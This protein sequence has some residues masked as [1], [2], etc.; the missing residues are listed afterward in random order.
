MPSLGP[1]K[2]VTNLSNC[3]ATALGESSVKSP[4]FIM[5]Y[6]HRYIHEL[7]D[8]EVSAVVLDTALLACEDKHSLLYA[9][10]RSTAGSRYYDLNNLGKARNAWDEALKIRKAILPHSSPGGE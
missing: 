5:T 7:G 4:V 1:L 6:F 3:W 9:D 2:A 10:L 8:Y